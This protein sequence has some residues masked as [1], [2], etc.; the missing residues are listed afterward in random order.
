M[1][2]LFSKK[3]WQVVGIIGSLVIVVFYLREP[4]WPTPDKLLIFLTF[5]FMA[6]GQA[7]AMLGRLLPF[8]VILLVY[9]SFRGIASQLNSHVNFLWMPSVDIK[10]FGSLPTATLQRWWWHGHVMWYDFVF[11]GTYMMHFI[12]PI[13]L[14]ILIWKKRVGYYWQVISTYVV[15]SFAGFLTYLLFPAAPPWMAS[16]QG[17]IQP[18]THVSN[19]IW[20][21][22]GF[23]NFSLAYSKIAPNPVAAVP[24]LHAAYA[25]LF[26]IFITKFFGKKWGLVS[27]VYPILIVVGTVYMGEHYAI[28]AILGILYAFASYYLVRWSYPKVAPRIKSLLKSM[29]TLVK[30]VV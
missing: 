30:K 3:L 11:Y 7:K 10:L 24:S 15:L 5:V 6:F 16:D 19:Y 29:E 28:D 18:L 9:E 26:V 13:A 4:S 25:T 21:S 17:Y 27:C 2:K 14:A 22:L 20:A 8:V 23:H 12:L 1:S